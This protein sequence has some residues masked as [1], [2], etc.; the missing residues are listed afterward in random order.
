[1]ILEE[2]TKE[3][4]VLVPVHVMEINVLGIGSLFSQLDCR[5]MLG[6]SGFSASCKANFWENY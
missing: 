1:M 5:E 2:K 3:E 6:I 4:L